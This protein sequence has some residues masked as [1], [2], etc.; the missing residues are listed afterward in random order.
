M[1]LPTPFAAISKIYNCKPRFA[2]GQLDIGIIAMMEELEQR[3]RA[4]F[5]GNYSQDSITAWDA[6]YLSQGAGAKQRLDT[7]L[8]T[9]HSADGLKV[10][11]PAGETP[12]DTW[13]TM[14]QC[15]KDKVRDPDLGVYTAVT[16]LTYRDFIH[17]PDA[18]YEEDY[19][20]YGAKKYEVLQNGDYAVI[21]FGKKKGWDN[22]PFLLCKTDDGWQF[23]IV[24][25]RRYIRMGRAPDWGVEFSEHPHMPMLMDTFYF[26]GQD[27]P[28]S[29]EDRYIVQKDS[30]LAQGIRTLEQQMK[31]EGD[32]SEGET[33]VALGRLYTIVS[34]NRKGMPLLKKALL[35]LPDD[36]RPHKYLAIAHVDAHYQYDTAIKELKTY[37]GKQPRD[38]FGHQFLGYLYYR[39]KLYRQALDAFDQALAIDPDDCYAHFYLCYVYAAL[40]RENHNKKAFKDQFD[41]HVAKTRSFVD[42][43]PLR[44]EWLNRWLEE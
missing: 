24:H 42:L 25:Q 1:S 29:E 40:Y 27:I 37:S 2:A 9:H 28:F 30:T 26:N 44:V 11:Y 33:L 7:P 15:W 19:R 6:E 16:R 14:I 32:A 31:A 17:L 12:S 23:D 8:P 13:R 43:H 39:Q 36:P 4:K 10:N 18:R 21:Y 3:A 22:A 34:M 20:T 41:I 5:Q 38:I 35:K